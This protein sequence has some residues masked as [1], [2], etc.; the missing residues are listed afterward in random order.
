ME[1]V[2]VRRS[3]IATQPAFA[4]ELSTNHKETDFLEKQSCNARQSGDILREVIMF[5][6]SEYRT[7]K[8]LNT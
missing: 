4:V 5:R 1:P 2:R 7:Q 8:G 3:P 6:H